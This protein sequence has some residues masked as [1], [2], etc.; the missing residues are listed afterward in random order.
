MVLHNAI[1]LEHKREDFIEQTIVPSIFVTGMA[2]ATLREGLY[3]IAAYVEQDGPYGPERIINLRFI[4][5]IG[6]VMRAIPVLLGLQ[7][8]KLMDA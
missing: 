5:P 3:H 6:G 7:R 4:V 8:P 1:N 2:Y